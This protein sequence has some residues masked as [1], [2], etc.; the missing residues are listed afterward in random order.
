MPTNSWSMHTLSAMEDAEGER[1]PGGAPAIVD[2]HVHVFPKTLFEAVWGWFG[3]HAWPIRYQMESE[4]LIQYL[5]SRGVAHVVALQYAHKGG[6]AV[7]LNRYMAGLCRRFSGQVTGMATVFPG[8]PDSEAVLVEAFDMGLSGVK[9]HTH[10]Q[11]FDMGSRELYAVC[12]ICAREGKPMVIHAGRE[13]V[14]PAYNCDPY[15]L[16]S[17]AKLE[18]ILKT[19]PELKIC[20]PHLGMNEFDAYGRL[21][22]TYDTLW[23][24]TT[25]ALGDFFPL[26]REIRL[27]ELRTD[28]IMYGT[29]FP[30]IPYAWDRELKKLMAHSL[31]PEALSK[32]LGEN[33]SAF[34]NIG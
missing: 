26:D 5:L 28:R 30:N 13:P 25:M 31:A 18:A 16:C 29:D 8:E 19:F 10:V 1:V 20:V 33:A 9:L 11:C 6:I 12:D 4:D 32:I 27:A 21:I 24:D 15:Q 23:L 34:Y 2:A 3:E 17:A 22:E 7:E 14:S